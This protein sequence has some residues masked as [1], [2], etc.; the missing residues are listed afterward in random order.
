MSSTMRGAGV[1]TERGVFPALSQA[2]TKTQESILVKSKL[3]LRRNHFMSTLK[4][5]KKDVNQASTVIFH[6]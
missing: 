2:V 6:G 1:K 5:A 3:L 4:P